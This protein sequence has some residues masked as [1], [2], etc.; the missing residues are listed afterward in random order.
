MRLMIRGFLLFLLLLSPI[1]AQQI[2]GR[3][4]AGVTSF[5]DDTAENHATVGGAV[6]FFFSRRW[7]VEPEY[8][9]MRKND[10]FTKHHDQ[11]FWGNLAFDFRHH[12]KVV[13]PYWFAAPGVIRSHTAFGSISHTNTEA[14]FGTGGGVKLVFGRVFVAP[15]VRVG[16]AD[17]IFAEVTGSVGVILKK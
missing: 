3:F 2:E 6:R 11:V 17:G 14:A 15:Q 5:V 4:T 1:A 8:L 10:D 7:S 12:D 9:Y 16:V 13:I